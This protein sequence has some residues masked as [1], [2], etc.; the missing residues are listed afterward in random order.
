MSTLKRQWRNEMSAFFAVASFCAII[1]VLLS[2]SFNSFELCLVALILG[3]IYF[4]VK[5]L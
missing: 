3:F 5:I 2:S 1:F 4:T